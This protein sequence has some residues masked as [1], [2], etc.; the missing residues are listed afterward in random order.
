M[1]RWFEDMV[2]KELTDIW[3]TYKGWPKP[4]IGLKRKA[5]HKVRP[6]YDYDALVERTK[7]DNNSNPIMHL[8]CQTLWIESERYY[9]IY[10]RKKNI[11]RSKKWMAY[12]SDAFYDRT[13]KRWDYMFNIIDHDKDEIF[14]WYPPIVTRL[15]CNDITDNDWNNVLVLLIKKRG[16]GLEDK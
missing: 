2:F 9:P 7:S 5:V 16:C 3:E 10:K 14:C 11:K 6:C 1:T 4:I 12:L 13:L 15:Y 8:I